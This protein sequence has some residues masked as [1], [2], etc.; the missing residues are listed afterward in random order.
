ML[1][2]LIGVKP[3]RVVFNPGTEDE[4]FENQFKEAGV[5]VLEACTLVMLHTNRYD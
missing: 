2:T 4:G 1:S 5:D 3:R